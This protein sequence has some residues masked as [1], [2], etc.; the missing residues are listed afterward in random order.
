MKKRPFC[1]EEI[2]DA[3]IKC[4]YCQTMLAE[5]TPVQVVG[6]A[7]TAAPPRVGFR[8]R[9]EE[10]LREKKREQQEFLR[11][12]EQAYARL[13]K[14]RAIR[15]APTPAELAATRR[16][17]RRAWAVLGIFLLLSLVAAAWLS[18]PHNVGTPHLPHRQT[19]PRSVVHPHRPPHHLPPLRR[20][21][22]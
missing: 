9:L 13:E 16:A 19:R 17:N 1:A 21:S 18:P 10:R 8:A 20:Q 22:M 15:P 6:P 5:A 12:R 7:P 4:R 2:Q 3:A 11:E 14:E